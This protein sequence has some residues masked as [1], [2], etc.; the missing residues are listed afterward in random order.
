MDEEP[1]PNDYDFRALDRS[2]MA[3]AD[4]LESVGDARSAATVRE[5]MDRL[6]DIPNEFSPDTGTD[7]LFL[8]LET[9]W[10][11]A[12]KLCEIIATHFPPSS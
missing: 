5:A 3:M 4:Q 10:K 6:R 2:V 1:T 8:A 7:E 12:Q 11:N 9:M